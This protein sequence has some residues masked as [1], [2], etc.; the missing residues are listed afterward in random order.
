MSAKSVAEK[1]LIKPNTT[2]WLSD[3]SRFELI[4]P[5]PEGVR[6]VDEPKRATT[7][8]VFAD[9]ADSLRAILSKQKD[10]LSQPVTFWIAYPKANR[11]NINR[12]TLWPMLNEYAMR[13]I[14]QIAVDEVWSAL[15]FRPLK[16]AEAP[17]TG[18][19]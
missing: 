6:A 3:S 12:D 1:L 17:F 13:P 19:R 2:V 14:G 4:E 7:A 8:L 15:R 10:Q 9:D 11:T 16:D 5:L 18:G